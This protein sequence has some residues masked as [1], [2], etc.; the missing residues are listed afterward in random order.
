[1]VTTDEGIQW[2]AGTASDDSDFLSWRHALFLAGREDG[3]VWLSGEGDEGTTGEQEAIHPKFSQLPIY[4][5]SSACILQVPP[6][7]VFLR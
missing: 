6:T 5:D 3:N 7:I 1:M 4:K 2:F